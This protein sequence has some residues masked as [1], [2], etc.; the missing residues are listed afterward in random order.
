MDF[1]NQLLQSIESDPED[2]NRLIFSTLTRGDTS[3]IALTLS[4][5]KR[6]T[7]ITLELEPTR[8][9]GG[10]PPIYRPAQAVD[11]ASVRLALR[12]LAGGRLEQTVAAGDYVDRIILRKIITDGPREVSFEITDT[13]EKQGDYYFVRIRQA[14]DAMA[15]SSP[16]WVGGYAKQ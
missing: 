2:T 4:G 8:E 3:S 13:G 6:S 14:N 10:A 1:H 5:V 11:G 9:T 15:W 12:D 16:I 7:N